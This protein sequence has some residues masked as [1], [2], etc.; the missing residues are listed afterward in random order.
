MCVAVVKALDRPPKDGQV[1][2]EGRDGGDKVTQI[3]GGV[4]LVGQGHAGSD[5]RRAPEYTPRLTVCLRVASVYVQL[6][7]FFLICA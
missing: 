4:G 7:V 5:C 3:R 6:L 2:A 1:T